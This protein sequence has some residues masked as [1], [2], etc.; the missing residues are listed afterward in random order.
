MTP[1]AEQEPAIYFYLALLAYE[2]RNDASAALDFLSKVPSSNLYYE[3]ALRFQ[4]H[5]LEDLKRYDEAFAL[6]KQGQQLFPDKTEFW[7]LEARLYESQ[8]QL[9]TALKL[10]DEAESKWPED[11]TL[12]YT[13][14]MILERNNRLDEAMQVMEHI[15]TLDPENADALNYVGYTLADAKKDLDRAYVLVHNA[16]VQE[17]DN[18]YIIDSL[19]WV[20]FRQGKFKEAWESHPTG[21]GEDRLGPNH[22]GTL[23]R[24]SFGPWAYQ[25]CPESL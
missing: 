25:R 20:H 24:H 9:D 18:G 13:R 14:G 21:C 4:V 8:N 3:R 17:P 19:A 22:M 23:R 7:V 16:L 15:I 2:G 1:E 6:V 5:L 10:L 12:L 11:T